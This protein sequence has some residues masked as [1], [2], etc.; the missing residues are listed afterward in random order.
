MIK[1]NLLSKSAKIS[2]SAMTSMTADGSEFA[3]EL[4][5]SEVQRKTAVNMLIMIL[6]P[7]G[8]Y[9]YETQTIPELKAK[10]ASQTQIL[11][12]LTTA[13]SAASNAVQEKKKFQTDEDRLKKQI[14][15]ME[16]LRND[17]LIE[18]KV[19]E[20][21]QKDIPY[22]V[23]IENLDLQEMKGSAATKDKAALP[24][25]KKL[26]IKGIAASNTDIALFVNILSQ[27]IYFSNVNLG[28]SKKDKTP[29]GDVVSFDLTA[30][31]SNTVK[32]GAAV[33]Q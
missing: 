8:M 22:R 29:L 20:L 24:N 25:T 28:A 17:R 30:N 5:E 13:I 32:T 1:I 21:L 15:I 33:G 31:I 11:S 16:D 23:S 7:V 18:L 6:I 19:F 10:I 12:Q 9:V 2:A 26:T 27:S 4:S 14:K 3:I